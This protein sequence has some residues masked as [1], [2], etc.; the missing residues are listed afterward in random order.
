MDWVWP[1]DFVLSKSF[2]LIK[3]YL[4][5]VKSNFESFFAS[6]VPLLSKCNV[7][8]RALSFI[9]GF[10]YRTNVVH[11]LSDKGG[12]L[13]F[14]NLAQYKNLVYT[15]FNNC[16]SYSLVSNMFVVNDLVSIFNS[17]YTTILKWNTPIFF[18][19]F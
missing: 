10:I 19:A 16:F 3:S 4:S 1:S 12:G 14:L 15:H 13:V 6:H 9:K 17:L 7:S 18:C 8:G 2:L 11:K 5:E